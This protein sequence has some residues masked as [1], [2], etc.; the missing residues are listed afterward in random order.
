[1]GPAGRGGKGVTGAVA[2]LPP[3]TTAPALPPPTTTTAAT[4]PVV[5]TAPTTTATATAKKPNKNDPGY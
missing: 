3:P 4:P 2:P 5:A 1:V